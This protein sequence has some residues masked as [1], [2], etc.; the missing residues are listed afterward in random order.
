M[1]KTSILSLCSARLHVYTF[2]TSTR[3][4]PLRD[5]SSRRGAP[6]LPQELEVAVGLDDHTVLGAA[7]ARG[8][9][10]ELAASGGDDF[11][12]DDSPVGS[13]WISVGR[14]AGAGRSKLRCSVRGAG[15]G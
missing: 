6:V 14:C 5:Q 10:E 15:A 3:P 2:Y 1:C 13:R 8:G 12:G 4:L 11:G 9:S 7:S